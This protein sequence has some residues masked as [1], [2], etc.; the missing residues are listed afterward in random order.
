MKLN[1][2]FYTLLA[3]H[4]S[5]S[6]YAAH[7]A[8]TFMQPLV[9]KARQMNWKRAALASAAVGTLGYSA[10]G[11]YAA[12]EP[13]KKNIAAFKK[14]YKHTK[15]VARNLRTRSYFAPFIT[16]GF[17]YYLYKKMMVGAKVSE[18][19]ATRIA[20]FIACVFG[21]A[22]FSMEWERAENMLG[23][24]A[25]GTTG[26]K[27]TLN[28]VKG[29]VPREIRLLVD[30]LKSPTKYKNIKKDGKMSFSKGF[31]F[32]G[33]PGT[34]KTYLARA[35]AGSL[36]V[37]FFNIEVTDVKS[38]LHGGSESQLKAIFNRARTAAK[39]HPQK[40]AVLFIDEIDALG[41]TRDKPQF[42]S[43]NILETLLALIDGFNQHEGQLIVIGAT[44]RPDRVDSALK[45][46][47]RLY[48]LIE[49]KSLDKKGCKDVLAY[50]LRQ[51]HYEHEQS[52]KSMDATL[53]T[54]VTMALAAHKATPVALKDLVDQ[55]ARE[56]AAQQHARITDKIL[57]QEA[58]QVFEGRVT[59]RADILSEGTD[60]ALGNLV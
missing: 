24:Q 4:F 31:L 40:L 11:K 29:G 53:E 25:G 44:N 45:R 58:R 13:G 43:I 23:M 36:G 35:I 59:E 6:L 12:T 48:P 5:V 37:P 52:E 27:I 17:S 50:Y 26:A 57:L 21:G 33:Q 54:I 15:A 49:I 9:H 56:S 8:K 18:R 28:D 2:I 14:Q 51:Y 42:G 19:D 32:Y 1:K 16:A 46:P 38:M 7:A 41:A 10:Y 3:M 34:G 30:Q 55:A 60:E 39:N 20:S 22:H 47:G